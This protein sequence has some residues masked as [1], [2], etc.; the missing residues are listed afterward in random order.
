MN[1]FINQILIIGCDNGFLIFDIAAKPPLVILI[2]T[3]VRTKHYSKKG[4][5]FK[6]GFSKISVHALN[7]NHTIRKD[8]IPWILLLHLR[9]S[10]NPTIRQSDSWVFFVFKVEIAIKT[11]PLIKNQLLLRFNDSSATFLL[12]VNILFSQIY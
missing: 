8:G 6:N 12:S 4:T 9:Q 7:E 5:L 1:A 2:I 11:L 10:D 3:S